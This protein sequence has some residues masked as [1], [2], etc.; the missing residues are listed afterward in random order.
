MA[1]LGT[2]ANVELSVARVQRES[3][4]TWALSPGSRP[5]PEAPSPKNENSGPEPSVLRA[6]LEG[7]VLRGWILTTFPPGPATLS[8]LTA[9][10]ETP[11]GDIVIDAARQFVLR[12]PDVERTAWTADRLILKVTS[13]TGAVAT[14]FV[15]FAD[16][17]EV[18]RHVGNMASRLFA[19]L[20]GTETPADVAA[21]MSWFH[22][23][24][25][26]LSS[27]PGSRG[28]EGHPHGSGEVVVADLLT[29]APVPVPE[30]GVTG[31]STSAPWRRFVELVLAS[32]REPRGPIPPEDDAD[33]TS[34]DGEDPAPKK[35]RASPN[36]ATAERPFR[37]F[38]K[39][40]DLM[41]K[42]T[43]A[44]RRR[45]FW[46]AHYVC[47]RLEPDVLRVRSYLQKVLDALLDQPTTGGDHEAIA[48]AHLVLA[49]DLRGGH[50]ATA[51]ARIA[52]RRL[53]RAG[54]DLQAPTP[55]MNPVRGFS[56]ALAPDFDFAALW[57]TILA[58]RT[59]QEEV[60]AF[61]LAGGDAELGAKFPYLRSLRELTAMTAS[62]RKAITFM[63]EFSN[64]CPRCHIALPI[65]QASRLREGGI[66]RHE[67][68]GCVLLCEEI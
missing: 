58:V 60:K 38:E 26:Y 9:S 45:A 66:A 54:V 51:L 6:V 1:A 44:N 10:A 22:D 23:H 63:A 47:D 59:A 43:L 36:A 68:C 56:R 55:D 3:V 18:R 14:G 5:A 16:F 25:D 4:V 33:D 2:E 24:P 65:A 8:H 27:S 42:G 20:S 12:A 62:E 53:L 40:L 48:A 28:G 37:V 19:V 39:L 17:T 11:V 61:R 29:A 46:M 67:R 41:V 30:G 7:K 15:S 52:R 35:A 21:V 49:A 57:T 13:P 34:N 31:S 32:F 64:S 50:D